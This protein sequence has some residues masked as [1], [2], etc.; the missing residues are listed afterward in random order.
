M[1]RL[2]LAY[3]RGVN[4]GHIR[5]P[6]C[7]DARRSEEAL[8]AQ[9][10]ERDARS[11]VRYSLNA[12]ATFHWKEHGVSHRASGET[13]DISHKGAYIAAPVCPAQGAIVSLNIY[14]PALADEN[15]PLHLEA[16]GRVLR[17]ETKSNHK[18]GFAV[19]NDRV[20]L[21]TASEPLAL[22]NAL[23]TQR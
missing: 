17:V 23:G 4:N 10:P 22:A 2:A 7:A 16:V 13:R 8:L 12:R 3:T 1:P 6:K 9:L 20:I 5:K 21:R 15:C 18:K 14:L 11:I 19:A